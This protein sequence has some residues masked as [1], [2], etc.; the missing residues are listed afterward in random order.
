[1]KDEDRIHKVQEGYQPGKG[2]LT[3]GYQVQQSV[4]LKQISVPK[5]LGDAAVTPV[6]NGDTVPTP[7]KPGKQ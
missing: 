5:N 2:E 4:D 3:R 7:A 6:N 1:M